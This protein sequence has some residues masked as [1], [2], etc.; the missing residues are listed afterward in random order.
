MESNISIGLVLYGSWDESFTY[1]NDFKLSVPYFEV[2]IESW[3][4]YKLPI[5]YHSHL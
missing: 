4:T 2:E 3:L 1:C 5:R